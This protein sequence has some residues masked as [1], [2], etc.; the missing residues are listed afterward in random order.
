MHPTAKAFRAAVEAVDLDALMDTMSDEVV[1]RSPVT[2][3]TYEGKEAVR[4]LLS[5]VMRVFEDF[6][7]VDEVEGERSA[8]LVFETRAGDREVNGIDYLE[9]GE[10]GRIERFTVMV[11][12]MSAVTRL[13]ESIGAELAKG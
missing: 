12:P 6:R 1:F 3:K 13:A 10:D 7:Y 11:R 2:F 5:I 8:I 9:F 4:Y